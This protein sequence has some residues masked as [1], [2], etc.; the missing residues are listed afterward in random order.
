M[1]VLPNKLDSTKATFYLFG[2]MTGT[3]LTNDVSHLNDIWFANSENPGVW[4]K[5]DLPVPWTPR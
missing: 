4:T 3:P 5:L 2:G 1:V